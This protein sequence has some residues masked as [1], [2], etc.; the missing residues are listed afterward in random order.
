MRKS[1]LYS[2]TSAIQGAQAAPMDSPPPKRPSRL[3]ALRKISP[4][5]PRLLW[6]AIGLLTVLLLV[7]DRKSTRLNSSHVVTSRMPSSA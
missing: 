3:A 1:A 2:S 7:R 4:N 6:S 5:D